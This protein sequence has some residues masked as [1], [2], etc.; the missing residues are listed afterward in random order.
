MLPLIGNETIRAEQVREQIAAGE[1]LLPGTFDHSNAAVIVYDAAKHREKG[2]S[3][4]QT[5]QTILYLV[6]IG[7]LRYSSHIA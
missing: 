3:S 1:L 6:D 4:K 2:F 7:K 5:L